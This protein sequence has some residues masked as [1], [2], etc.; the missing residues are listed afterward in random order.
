MARIKNSQIQG[1]LDRLNGLTVGHCYRVANLF[2]D[3]CGTDGR[4]HRT[5]YK[6]SSRKDLYYT[7]SNMADCLHHQKYYSKR[8][9]D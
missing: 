7:L 8:K 5:L 2:I 9:E 6:A 1:Q 3:V 4:V